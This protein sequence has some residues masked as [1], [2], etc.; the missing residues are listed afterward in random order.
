M[1]ELNENRFQTGALLCRTMA[2]PR[3]LTAIP[4]E[5]GSSGLGSSIGRGHFAIFLSKTFY[6]HSASLHPGV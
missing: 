2:C 1:T 4:L 5:F 6:S 3:N